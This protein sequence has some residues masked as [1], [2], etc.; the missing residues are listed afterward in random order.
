MKVNKG[1]VVQLHSFLNSVLDYLIS[2]TPRSLYSW[3]KSVR[4]ALEPVRPPQLDCPYWTVW[5][6]RTVRTGQYGQ[7]GL[8][9]TDSMD[10]TDC[11]YWTV[12]TVRTVRTGQG[13]SPL[14]LLAI[15]RL[16]NKHVILITLV[17]INATNTQYSDPSCGKVGYLG[18]VV[19]SSQWRIFSRM[20]IMEW[21]MKQAVCLTNLPSGS[22]C[23]MYAYSKHD[24]PLAA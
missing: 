12:W 23:Y 6:V 5:T 11:T 8:Y 4:Q 24:S 13:T 18:K 7:Y 3:T 21:L 2:F 19:R 14:S 9:V 15:E 10:S 20:E 1:V 16:F 22:N 17:S